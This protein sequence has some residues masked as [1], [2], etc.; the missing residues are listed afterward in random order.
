[1]LGLLALNRANNSACVLNCFCDM[2]SG[3]YRFPPLCSIL[4][5]F[6]FGVTITLFPRF[7]LSILFTVPTRMPC[8][9]HGLCISI[10]NFMAV[11]ELKNAALTNCGDVYA[12][13]VLS[14]VIENTLPFLAV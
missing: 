4:Y 6:P 1:M 7:T 11:H 10:C 5:T 8:H 14:N 3:E 9:D 13:L 12:A 2:V